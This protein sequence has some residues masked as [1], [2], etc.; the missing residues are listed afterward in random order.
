MRLHLDRENFKAII[1]KISLENNIDE[2]I[3]EKDYYVCCILK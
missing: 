1:N 3:L 2:D